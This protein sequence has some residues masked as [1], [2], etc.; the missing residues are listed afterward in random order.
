MKKIIGI[1]LF[2]SIVFH[3]NAQTES[4]T[5]GNVN[6]VKQPNIIVVPYTTEGQDVRQI[7]ENNRMMSNAISKI[8]EE[9][10]NRGFNTKDFIT[11]LQASKRN[12]IVSETTGAKTDPVKDLVLESKADISVKVKVFVIQHEGGVAEV[13]LELEA[14]E[15]L[16]GESFANA[17]YT[18]D[19]FRT[20]DSLGLAN[21]ALS[22]INDDFF[23]LIQNGFN[24]MMETG[25]NLNIRIE[26]GANSE[27][28]P[29]SEMNTGNDLEMELTNWLDNN[30]YG[31]NY[32]INSSDKVIDI[33]MKVPIYDQ[34]TGKPYAVNKIRNP[35]IK[36]L[37]SI[38]ETPDQPTHTPSTKLSSNQQIWIV[39]E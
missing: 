39:I 30:A 15:A 21:R 26:L 1:L 24:M 29:Y 19:K 17:S 12:D 11:L 6:N 33:S 14:A 22:K 2:F 3:G 5:R 35:L 36:F 32:E 18:S 8:K 25:R 23:T 31:G 10:N 34:L 38:L 7:L 20:A 37:K 9:F 27:L 4:A 13:N 28:D 16:S